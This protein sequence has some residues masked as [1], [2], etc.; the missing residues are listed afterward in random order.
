AGGYDV[1]E[2]SISMASKEW[3]TNTALVDEAN[4]RYGT[5]LAQMKIFYNR[6]RIIFK[7]IGN[8]LMEVLIDIAN[9]LTP[10]IDKIEAWTQ[11]LLDADGA[12]TP[13][14]KALGALAIALTAVFAALIP[15]RIITSVVGMLLSMVRAIS[16]TE[17]AF[18]RIFGVILGG[19]GTIVPAIV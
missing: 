5:F 13:L 17:V 2:D 9:A 15:L 4:I 6:L 10:L 11:T 16:I 18:A 7:N 3:E 19:I 1:L 12:V 14:G 8:V